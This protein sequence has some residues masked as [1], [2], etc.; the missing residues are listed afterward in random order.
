MKRARPAIRIEAI[1]EA[2]RPPPGKERRDVEDFLGLKR[3]LVR[4]RAVIRL[5][6][7]IEMLLAKRIVHFIEDGTQLPFPVKTQPEGDRIEPE[8]ERA[9]HGDKDNLAGGRGQ[10]NAPFCQ[11]RPDP[12]CKVFTRARTEI[13]VTERERRAAVA[14]QCPARPP[15]RQRQPQIIHPVRK[16]MPPQKAAGMI[17]VASEKGGLTMP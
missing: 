3:I 5:A 8:P 13:A 2:V 15:L 6:A 14:A 4:D 7:Q 16:V 11:A 12:A 9:R 10:G 1:E 17:N